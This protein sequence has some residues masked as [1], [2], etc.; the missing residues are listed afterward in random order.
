MRGTEANKKPGTHG[1]QGG[2]DGQADHSKTDGKRV[3]KANNQ[4]RRGVHGSNKGSGSP[5]ENPASVRPIIESIRPTV[6]PTRPVIA[7]RQPVVALTRVASTGPQVAT[8][9][10]QM[11]SRL[12]PGIDME[13]EE[14]IGFTLVLH[15][16]E[17]I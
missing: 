6:A 13:L 17:D 5:T 8:A 11:A 7:S 14:L 12:D 15:A 1:D 4:P 10:T 3:V 16:D 9:I 2:C